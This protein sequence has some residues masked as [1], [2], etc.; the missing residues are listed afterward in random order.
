[1]GPTVLDGGCLA[2]TATLL[3][4]CLFFSAHDR[5]SRSVCAPMIV[6]RFCSLSA[7]VQVLPDSNDGNVC[8]S[9]CYR[10]KR[11]STN[12]IS[13]CCLY[14]LRFQTCYI[15]TQHT[16]PAERTPSSRPG[17]QNNVLPPAPMQ[18]SRPLS[19]TRTSLLF[20]PHSTCVTPRFRL[21]IRH[22]PLPFSALWTH[23]PCL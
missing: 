8:G 5:P 23:T 19:D 13:A 15:D 20:P 22:C 16:R 2:I 21:T 7:Q 14:K 11:L 12:K 4:F 18:M 1:M 3:L 17:Y 6:H 9:N 10:G